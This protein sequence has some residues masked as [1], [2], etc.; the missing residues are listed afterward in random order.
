MIITL[1]LGLGVN[2]AMFSLLDR[3]Y[4]RMPA[5]VSDPQ[6]LRRL[7]TPMLDKRGRLAA[8]QISVSAEMH[9]RHVAAFD[10]LA[11]TALFAPQPSVRLGN[12]PDEVTATVMRASA[13]FLP[14]LG[15]ARQEGD[16]S[17]AT[18]RSWIRRRA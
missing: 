12:D 1:A 13:E 14:V 9:A 11:T 17:P 7:W 3:V 5:G 2:A 4:L 6:S 8:S 10:S 18:K 16:C 15:V